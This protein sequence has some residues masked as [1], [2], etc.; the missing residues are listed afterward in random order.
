MPSLRT[1]APLNP[2]TEMERDLIIC[3]LHGESQDREAFDCGEP[4]LNDYLRRTAW[5]HQR[6]RIANTYVLVRRAE[7]E[8]ILGFFTLSFLEVEATEIPTGLRKRLPS[9]RLPAARLG[10]LAVDRQCQGNDCGRLLLVD[11]LRRV[12]HAMKKVAG[13]VGLDEYSLPSSSTNWCLMA[14]YTYTYNTREY[15]ISARQGLI[16]TAPRFW[17]TLSRR[18]EQEI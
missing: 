17:P 13:V 2:K 7:P 4:A 3:L 10:R 15:I 9:S 16:I 1:P 5:Q 12:A 6:K 14:G 8:R 18:A 11:A